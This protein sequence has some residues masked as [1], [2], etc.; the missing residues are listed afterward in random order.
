MNA[1]RPGSLRANPRLDQWLRFEPD[2]AVVVQSGKV[3]IGQG[4]L[5]ALAQV[6]AQELEVP[7]ARVRMTAT[8]TGSHPDEGVTSGSLSLQDSGTALR[9]V[10]REARVLHLRE[11]ARRWGLPADAVRME[12]GRFEAPD[13]R[14]VSYADLAEAHL[15]DGEVA[16]E[17]APAAATGGWVG[18]SVPRIDIPDKVIGRP[19]FIHDIDEPGLLHGRVQR[20]PNPEARVRSV[21]LEAARALP[22]VEAVV[23]DGLQFGLLAHS[24]AQAD[25]ALASLQQHLQWDTPAALPDPDRLQDWLQ[26][27]PVETTVAL[28]RGAPHAAATRTL[29]ATYTRPFVAHASMAPSCALARWNGAQLEV[30]AHTQGVYNLR[31]DLALAFGCADA[32]VVVQHVEGAGCYGHNGADDVAWDAAWL[33]RQVPGRRVRVLWTR[34]GEFTE[35]PHGP[36]G[37]ARLEADVDAAGRVIGWR[38]ELWSPGHSSRPGRAP[39][40]TLLGS[41]Y[42]AQAFPRLAAQN[43]PAANGGGAE[44]NAVPGYEFAHVRVVSHRV[45]DA[46]LR[47]SALRGLGALLNVFAAESFMD[48]VAAAVDVDPVTFRLRHL[49]DPRGHDVIQRAVA[50]SG[51]QPGAPQAEGVGCGIGYARYKGTGAWCA[52]VAEVEVGAEVRVRKLSVAADIGLV[53]NPDGAANQ[54]EGGAIQ[55]TSVTLKE[56]VRFERE[57]ITS[58]DWESYPILRFT[59]VPAVEVDL[60]ESSEPSL[61]AGEASFGPTAAAIANAVH[62]A[63]GLRVRELPLTAERLLAA[64]HAGG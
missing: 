2:G 61:G 53:V 24:S 3:E 46:A 44:R 55:A 59:E 34:A 6:A 43:V 33:A 52:V 63:I 1:A 28:E 41:W 19:R 60:V 51:W 37:V 16:G 54:L 56:A 45:L 5:T 22:G 15:L 12:E 31:R 10:C 27:T 17:G 40:P 11:A 35:D 21:D 14:S 48:E 7:L 18:R 50:R 9:Q 36:A 62:D 58:V 25:A 13:G 29:V 47:A 49:A 26:S 38:H 4:I 20:P 30:H 57:R 23:Q 32:D 42:T 8:R 39:T 64:I